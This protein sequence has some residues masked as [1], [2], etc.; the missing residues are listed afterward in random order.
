MGNRKTTI[1][2]NFASIFAGNRLR[3]FIYDCGRFRGDIFSSNL[4]EVAI[5]AKNLF[6]GPTMGLTESQ[7]AASLPRY[8]RS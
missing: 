5:P 7:E 6:A 3:Y 1:E 2:I 4:L 8:G